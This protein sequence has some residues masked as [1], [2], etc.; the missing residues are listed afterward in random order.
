MIDDSS[1]KKILELTNKIQSLEVELE[2]QRR[3]GELL[4]ANVASAQNENQSLSMT[5]TELQDE[6]RSAIT[7]LEE[8]QKLLNWHSKGLRVE[9]ENLKGKNEELRSQILR[10]EEYWREIQER[11]YAEIRKQD[12]QRQD[13]TG[14][15]F[16]SLFRRCEDWAW[17]YFKLGVG[18]FGIDEF[19]LFAHEL[20]LVSWDDTNWKHKARFRVDHLVQAVLGNILA[21]EV[22]ACPFAGCAR[23]FGREFHSLYEVKLEGNHRESAHAGNRWMD[24]V[25]TEHSGGRTGSESLASE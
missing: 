10:L 22:L 8:E 19:P 20:E 7:Q 6:S 17:R 16:E 23:D 5:I 3:A 14:A 9:N 11:E 13:I 21:R 2:E 15:Q 25:L 1:K 12:N 18:D 4:Y 24:T